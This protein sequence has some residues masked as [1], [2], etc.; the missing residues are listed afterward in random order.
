MTVRSSPR[1]ASTAL[2]AA[3]IAAGGSAASA[4]DVTYYRSQAATRLNLP[5]SDAVIV[6]DLLILS[7]QLGNRPGTPELVEGGITAEARQAMDNI[8]AVLQANGSSFD[9]VLKCTI[10]LADI[11]DWPAFNAVY[12]S[13]FEAHYPARSA[14]ATSG[15][16]LGARVEVECIARR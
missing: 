5:F 7:G 1:K 16:A 3:F 12:A 15:L 13:Y 6:G 14:F 2:C 8:G 11:A 10:M 4:A 9:K